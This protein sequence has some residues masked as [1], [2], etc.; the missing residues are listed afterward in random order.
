M[1]MPP[2]ITS[3]YPLP[4][5]GM[6]M[7]IVFHIIH[8]CPAVPFFFCY[9]TEKHHISGIGHAQGWLSCPLS[10]FRIRAAQVENQSSH[11]KPPVLSRIAS[12][13]FMVP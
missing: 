12:V 13:P 11:S 1:I 5:F 2:R 3:S 10:S 9:L 4:Y 8:Y 7:Q 6:R